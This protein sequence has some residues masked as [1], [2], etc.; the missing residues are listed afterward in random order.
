L[1]PLKF[2]LSSEIAQS[3]VGISLCQHKYVLDILSDTG[4]LAAN[5]FAFPMESN[6]KFST[7]DG[8]LLDDPKFYRMLIGRLLYL[9]ITCPDLTYVDHA[10]EYSRRI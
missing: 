6:T 5:P 4:H 3:T 10:L 9:T 1:G 8:E 7:S 2:F